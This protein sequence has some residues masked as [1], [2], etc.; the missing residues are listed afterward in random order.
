MLAPDLRVITGRKF[1]PS[2]RQFY[3]LH[4]LSFR[5]HLR[6]QGATI[7]QLHG[8]RSQSI[9]FAWTLVSFLGGPSSKPAHH[10]LDWQLF[11]VK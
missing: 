7:Q 10:L 3:K 4:I 2:I 5:P 8:V 1:I 11:I 6:P 9:V